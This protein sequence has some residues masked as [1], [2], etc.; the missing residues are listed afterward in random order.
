[1]ELYVNGALRQQALGAL[2]IWS[3]GEIVD[4]ALAQ[5]EVDFVTATDLVRITPCDAIPARTL[6]L[7]GT[8]AGVMFHPVTVWSERAYL[9][10][11]DEVVSIATHLGVL[12]NVV[13]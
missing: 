7:T 8:P 4:Q 12:R 11:G 5:C 1:M 10:P 3:P 2:M 9:Q 6:I 13:R